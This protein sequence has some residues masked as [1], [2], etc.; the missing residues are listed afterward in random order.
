MNFIQTGFKGLNDW[1][2]YLVTLVIIFVVIQ[3][4]SLPLAFFALK[5]V[6]FDM[7]EFQ[8]A[9]QDN[10]MK[11]GMDSSLF[12]FLM[13]LTFIFGIFGLFIGVKF[14]HKKKF[15]WII[16]SRQK[17]DWNRIFYAF[18][19]WAFV[20]FTFIA[21]GIYFEPELYIWNFKL[22]PFLFLVFV[23]LVFLPF[24]T[25]LEE[26]IFRGYLMQGIGLI[27]KNK[28]FPLV[29]TSVVFGLLHGANPEIE[30]LGYIA[31]V[32]YIGTGFFFGIVTLLDEGTELA[33]GLHAANNIVAA[34]FVTADW[35]VFQT[36]ALYIDTSEPSVGLEMFLPVF[37]VY[38]IMILIFSK[39]YG[40]T[41]WKQKLFG[42]VEEPL[43]IEE[44]K[45]KVATNFTN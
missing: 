40:W 22:V 20:S 26:F 41:N 23:S 4:G 16:T 3:I 35:T 11:T 14:I 29:I 43:L 12:L 18:F 36:D 27:A 34:I 19:L 13:I 8:I 17:V 2:M 15:K 42:K 38:P 5:E 1:W 9:A 37:V 25:S 21:I 7:Q 31:L 33:L 30:K 44:I 39:K 24:Q 28:W 45:K 10:F 32:F 6:G